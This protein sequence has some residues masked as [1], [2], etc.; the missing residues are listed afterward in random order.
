MNPAEILSSDLN[1]KEETT[2]VCYT[3]NM[4]PDLNVQT[5]IYLFH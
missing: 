5:A 1:C 2:S 3:G 4:A